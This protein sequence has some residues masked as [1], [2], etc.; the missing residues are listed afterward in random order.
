VKV[1]AVCALL[2]CVLDSRRAAEQTNRDFLALNPYHSYLPQCSL[3]V[4]IERTSL[5]RRVWEMTGRGVI[6]GNDLSDGFFMVFRSPSI[7]IWSNT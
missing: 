5:L 4:T 7:Q 3:D 1:R 2:P 6:R